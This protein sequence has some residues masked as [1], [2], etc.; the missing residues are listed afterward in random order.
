[1]FFGGEYF[2]EE[3]TYFCEDNIVDINLPADRIEKDE[4]RDL[5]DDKIPPSK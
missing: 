5:I 2:I 3:G 1:M 4:T